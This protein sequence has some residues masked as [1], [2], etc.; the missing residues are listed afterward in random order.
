MIYLT[1]LTKEIILKA[2]NLNFLAM[3][4]WNENTFR[5]K[6]KIKTKIKIVFQKIRNKIPNQHNILLQVK[7]H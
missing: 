3:I 5:L 4:F 7:K 2:M 1:T 6:I